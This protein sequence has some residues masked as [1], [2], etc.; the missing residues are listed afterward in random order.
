[1]GP[2]DL[3]A[4]YGGEE[5][6]LVLPETDAGALRVAERCQRL[7]EKLALPH[8]QNPHGQ[9]VTVSIGVGTVTPAPGPSRRMPCGRWTSSSTG[10]S[11]KAATAS[12]PW[13]EALRNA[14]PGWHAPRAGVH[15]DQRMN[16]V[17]CGASI[18]SV[19]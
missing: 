18:S 16:G 11:R 2:R 14:P 10:P 1:V 9:R 5:F 6:V 8:A 15:A 19:R 7:I 3:V 4:R 13:S 12:R 17:S